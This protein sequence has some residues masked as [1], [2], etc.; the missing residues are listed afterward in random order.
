MR[1]LGA[2]HSVLGYWTTA[3][4]D[5]ATVEMPTGTGKTDTMIG[6]LAALPIPRPENSRDGSQGS[7]TLGRRTFGGV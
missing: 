2:V 7:G 5:P 6:L 3:G 4:P 1:Q